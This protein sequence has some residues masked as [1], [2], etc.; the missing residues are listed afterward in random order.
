MAFT[1]DIPVIETAVQGWRDAA[2]ARK[3]MPMVFWTAIGILIA[4]SI[5]HML[6]GGW[7]SFSFIVAVI[8]AL[9][10]AAALTPLA[11][12]VH[13][14]VL[15]GEAGDRYD[16]APGDPR[17]QK[18]FLFTIALNV[19]CAIPAI[20]ALPLALASPFLAGIV[21]LIL[22]IAIVIVC[23][24]TVIVFPSIAVDAPG[25]DWRNAMADAKGHSWRIFFVLF[26]VALPAVVVELVLVAIFSWMWLL[27]TI[28]AALIAPVITVF[29]LA[30]VAAVASRLYAAYANQLGRPP[31]V[32]R[33]VV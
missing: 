4:L 22:V 26:C 17:F 1:T 25:A 24:R 31:N 8:L 29:L 9:A 20:I 19:L 28:V 27:A 6:I 21:V 18:F 15:L 14:F 12:A 13:R 23:V 11:I 30:A 10:Q 2:A 7:G 3:K 16:F 32:A 33:A 5:L